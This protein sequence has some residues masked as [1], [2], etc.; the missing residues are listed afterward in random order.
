MS[1]RVIALVAAAGQGTR[2]G[3]PI[4]KA[5]VELDGVPLLARSV[6]LLLDSGRVDEVIVLVSPDME[7]TAA[8]VL[9]DAQLADAPVRL[10]HGGGERADSVWA[11][12]R[13][14]AADAAS[15]SADA[16][17]EDAIVLVHDA[18]RAL[19]PPDMVA[20]IVDRVA[21]GA[22]AVIPVLPVADTIKEIDGDTV[23]ATPDRSRL[24]AVQTPQGFDLATLIRANEAYFA[25]SQDFIAT[26][27]ASLMEWFGDTVVTVPGD[28]MAFKITTPLDLTL[29]RAVLAAQP[30]AR[31]EK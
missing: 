2:L 26:D 9:A 13:A 27:D 18:A 7:D 20:R 28:A 10:V 6:R 15:A 16:S 4:P 31:D 19:T 21:A 12:L 14:A 5:Y 3:A 11:G 22:S 1:R 17:H 8:R 23:L 24:R 25:S 30:A 29:A